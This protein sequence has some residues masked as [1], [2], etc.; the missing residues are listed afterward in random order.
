MPKSTVIELNLSVEHKELLKQKADLELDSE[1]S[2]LRKLLIRAI[3][4]NNE[5]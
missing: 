3:N 1:S 2:Y 4:K 5:K